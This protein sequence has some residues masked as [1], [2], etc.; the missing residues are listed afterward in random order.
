VS[1]EST[2]KETAYRDLLSAIRDALDVPLC[3]DDADD[4]KFEMLQRER[5]M[6]AVG[7]IDAVLDE[8]LSPEIM[9]GILR[10]LVQESP[11]T[12]RPYVPE[13]LDSPAEVV[14]R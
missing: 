1:T 12:Y 11:V 3:A 7:T 10:D 14:T 2:T 8:G 6:T 5:V 13:A 9:T 4:H